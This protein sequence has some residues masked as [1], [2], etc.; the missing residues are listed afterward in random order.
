MAYHP[1]QVSDELW[2]P[3]QQI[4]ATKQWPLAKLWDAKGLGTFLRLSAAWGTKIDVTNLQQ[5]M[6]FVLEVESWLSIMPQSWHFRVLFQRNIHWHP[7]FPS[8]GPCTC[9]MTQMPHAHFGTRT[10]QSGLAKG[11]TLFPRR[12]RGPWRAAHDICR[13]SGVLSVLSWFLAEDEGNVVTFGTRNHRK[14]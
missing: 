5:P 2:H 14:R 9:R 3:A 10:W 8:H 12:A 6:K 1:L 7:P 4:D 11:S 13:S